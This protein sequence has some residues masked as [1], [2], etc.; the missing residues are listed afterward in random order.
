MTK[1]TLYLEDDTAKALRQLAN[2]EG[3]SES[4]DDIN[5]LAVRRAVERER[6]PIIVPTAILSEIDYLLRAPNRTGPTGR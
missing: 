4:D 3:C 6:G 5:H 2:D 1:T